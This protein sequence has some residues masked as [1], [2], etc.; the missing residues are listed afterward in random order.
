MDCFLRTCSYPEKRKIFTKIGIK[1]ITTTLQA[2]CRITVY[3]FMT[4]S[5]FTMVR[6][7]E[8]FVPKVIWNVI[9]T[10]WCVWVYKTMLHSLQSPGELLNDKYFYCSTCNRVL[11]LINWRG[12]RLLKLRELLLAGHS[13]IT[14]VR[15]DNIFVCPRLI[16]KGWRAWAATFQELK[17]SRWSLT[18]VIFVQCPFVHWALNKTRKID[19][20]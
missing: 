19:L 6:H 15:T 16:W 13:Q 7:E 18:C 8:F 20:H 4:L 9:T 12:S 17:K 3:E 2:I 14:Q 10:L 11:D 5:L 1:F